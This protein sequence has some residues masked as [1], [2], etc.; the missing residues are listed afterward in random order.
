M[1]KILEESEVDTQ[2]E[3]V[4]TAIEV[5]EELAFSRVGAQQN[6]GDLSDGGNVNGVMITPRRGGIKMAKGRPNVRQAWMW[7]GTSSLLTLAWNPE[8]TQHDG[9][10]HYLRKRTC[11]CCKVGG[12]I[13]RRGQPFACPT[14]AK[15]NCDKCMAG[16]DR[17]HEVTLG[18]GTLIKGYVI[19]TFYLSK[20]L[21]PFPTKFFGDIDCFLPNC[22]RTGAKGFMTQEDMRIHARSRHKLEYLAWIEVKEATRPDEV[23]KL[24]ARLDAVLLQLSQGQTPVVDPETLNTPE[25]SSEESATSGEAEEAPLYISTKD[26]TE[27]EAKGESP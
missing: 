14:C 23:G 16:T 2:A 12:I 6:V 24:Q 7:D 22:V 27:M 21:V 4:E 1:P 20:A 18:D 17:T 26:R 3:Q 9:A 8:G 15:T 25:S 19:P 10:R 11:L 5:A 13:P